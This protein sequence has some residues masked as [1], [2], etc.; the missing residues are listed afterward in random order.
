MQPTHGIK[1][2]KSIINYVYT[3]LA[4]ITDETRN[5]YSTHS[6]CFKCIIHIVLL[7]ATVMQFE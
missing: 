4:K 2:C 5:T 1:A 6:S 7:I 3:W